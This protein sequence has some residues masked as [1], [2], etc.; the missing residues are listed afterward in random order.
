MMDSLEMHRLAISTLN[1]VKEAKANGLLTETTCD[2]V[3]RE[4]T[5][6]MGITPHIQPVKAQP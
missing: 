6:A 2:A 3:V 1:A 5:E 4:V